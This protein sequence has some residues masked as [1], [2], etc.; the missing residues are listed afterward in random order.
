MRGYAV[1]AYT[2]GG[3][4]GSGGEL[5]VAGP[6]DVADGSLVTDW[7][8]AH[9]ETQADPERI[10]LAGISCGSGI[11]QLVAHEDPRV[12][13]VVALSTWADL[14][15]ALYDNQA[16]CNLKITTHATTTVSNAAP[17]HPT[18]VELGLQATDYRVPADH[19][20]AVILAAQDPLYAGETEPGT[21]V[22]LSAACCTLSELRKKKGAIVLDA[23]V[24]RETSV[25]ECHGLLFKQLSGG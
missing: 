2:E 6:E 16:T 23:M 11:G 13:A 4:P 15:E 21:V 20:L 24:L 10:G 12:K 1:V 25:E 17:E 14:G 19:R 7:A 18:A 5:T 22:T 3:L 9:P 8:L